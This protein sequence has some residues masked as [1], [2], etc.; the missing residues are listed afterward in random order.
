[1]VARTLIQKAKTCSHQLFLL[2]TSPLFRYQLISSYL[3][4]G[5]L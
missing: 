1:M 3:I 4:K 5:T 2:L